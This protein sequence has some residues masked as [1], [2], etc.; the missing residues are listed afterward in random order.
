MTLRIRFGW[1][2]G[3]LLAGIV[4]VV[5]YYLLN[6][7]ELLKYV[8]P[9]ITKITLIEADIHSDT[10]F[11]K[12]HA[13]A[14]NKAP[15]HISVDSIICDLSIGGT[16]LLSEKEH[17]GL[18]QEPNQ[19]DTVLFTVKVPISRTQ[20]K[21]NSLQDQDSTGLSLHVTIV[22]SS[23]KIEFTKNETIEVPIPPR[24][25]IVKTEQRSVKPFKKELKTDL[26]LEIIN[27]GKN[28]DLSIHDL[29][30]RITIGH[31]LTT[32]GKYGKSI[33]IKPRSG[34]V[35]VFPLHFRM[36]QPAA[37]IL[38]VWTDTDRVPYHLRLDAAIDAGKMKRIPVIIRGSGTLEMRK[39]KEHREKRRAERK[40]DG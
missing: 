2:A 18:S 21:I 13:I 23:R 38:K 29:R 10:A 27:D 4:G 36:Q 9:E 15:Y 30:Y 20:N 33:Y 7:K 5:V 22:Y 3:I 25:R 34:E 26:Y 19:A 32:R 1:A 28:L 35:L 16:K 37:T 12:I 11:I 14:Q 17:V 8:V 31:D 40:R 6:K 39:E 24:L